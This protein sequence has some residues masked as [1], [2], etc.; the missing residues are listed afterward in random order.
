MK[1]QTAE[2]IQKLHC[3]ISASE[4]LQDIL[5]MLTIK[6]NTFR[7]FAISPSNVDQEY[8]S[9]FMKIRVKFRRS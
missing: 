7:S 6:G 5:N 4:L 8:Y 2:P 9:W 3:D 1:R